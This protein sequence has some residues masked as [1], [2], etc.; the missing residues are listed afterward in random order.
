MSSKPTIKIGHLKLTDHLVLGVT[1][2]RLD[3]GEEKFENCTMETQ[4]FAGWN[5]LKDALKEGSVDAAFILAPLA[6]DLF[7][8]GAKI[9]LTLFGHRDGSVI[10][11]NKRANIQKI[12]DFKGKT[13]LIPHY[14]SIHHLIFDRLLREKGLTV[15]VGKDVVFETVAPSE[16]PDIIAWDE[17]GKV[18]G[19]IVAEPYASQVV[20]AGDGEE[21][22]LSKDIWPKHPCCILVMKE[23]I[24]GKYPDAIQ[25]MVSSFVKSGNF[26]EQDP[27]AAAEI[28]ARFLD[29]KIEVV[30]RVLSRKHV[31]TG[32]LFPSAE[33][34]EAMQNYLTKVI[35]VMTSKIDLE[36]FIDTQF[37]K[38]A[39]A[40]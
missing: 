6:M 4:Y 26:I 40:K 20:L 15:G 1:K 38:E 37:A 29:Q 31:S 21:F 18:G 34:L 23:E 9:R 14:L 10:I 36:K 24:I 12:E 17:E 39:G 22:A 3:K 30:D 25:E 33:P 7:S 2:D 13:V 28:G 11:K 8:A 27:K 5:P 35:P 19:F 16:I 32:E